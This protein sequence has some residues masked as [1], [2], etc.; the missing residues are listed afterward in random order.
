MPFLCA[1]TPVFDAALP[2]FEGLVGD[3]QSQTSHDFIHIAICNG[4]ELKIKAYVESLN[5][6]KFHYVSLGYQETPTKESLLA[7]IGRRRDYCLQNFDAERYVF[8][9]ADLQLLT[10]DYFQR[11]KEHHKDADILLT[12]V[13]YQGFLLPKKPIQCGHIDMA[14]FSFNRRVAKSIHYPCDFDPKIGVANDW[15]YF[16]QITQQYKSKQLLLL[17]AKKNGRNSYPILSYRCADGGCLGHSHKDHSC[18]SYCNTPYC[19]GHAAI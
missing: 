16:N 3:L 12:R 18:A 6:S 5:D 17:S 9:D 4:D 13:A 2:S 11:L 10:C 15:R 19:K 14:N 7:E 1:I 8:L